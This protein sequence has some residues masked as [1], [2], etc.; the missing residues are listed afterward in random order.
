M[1]VIGSLVVA[2]YFTTIFVALPGAIVW[3]W[4]RWWR[5]PRQ[6]TVP[7]TLSLVGFTLATASGALAVSTF[8]Y[9]SVILDFLEYQPLL[10]RI[11]GWGPWLS[12]AA[13]VFGIFG[14]WRASPLRWFAPL[15]AAGTL[16]F[17]CA[18]AI[19]E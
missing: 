11:Y 16:L 7:S 5:R 14:V 9:A 10:L 4:V 13:V 19:S 2:L 18:A 3:G 17:W 12:L 6:W 1:G 8:I 15:C